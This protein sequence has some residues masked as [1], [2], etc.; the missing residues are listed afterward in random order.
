MSELNDFILQ[1]AT[2]DSFDL[3]KGHDCVWWAD[4]ALEAHHGFNPLAPF[5]GD[6]RTEREAWRHWALLMAGYEDLHDLL[7][8]FGWEMLDQ[9]KQGSAV[10]RKQDDVPICVGVISWRMGVLNPHFLKKEGVVVTALEDD[11]TIW[12]PPCR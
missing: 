8:D 11:D 5:R 12:W 2:K 7:T 3:S 9:P 4:R 6:Y 10:A 1:S